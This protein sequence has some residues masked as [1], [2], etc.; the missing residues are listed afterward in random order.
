MDGLEH[1]LDVI[2]AEAIVNRERYLPI[3]DF[4]KVLVLRSFKESDRLRN[5]RRSNCRVRRAWCTPEGFGRR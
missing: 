3:S 4:Q 2:V 5:M 1:V